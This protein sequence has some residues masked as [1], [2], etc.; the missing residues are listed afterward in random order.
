MIS[1]APTVYFLHSICVWVAL[2][3]ML[4]WDGVDKDSIL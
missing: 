3:I 1:F 2:F 4:G